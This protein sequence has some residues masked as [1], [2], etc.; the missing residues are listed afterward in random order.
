MNADLL[1]CPF[2]G[3]KPPKDLSDTLYPSGIYRRFEPEIGFT[4][5]IGRRDRL[6]T[7]EPC[8]AMHCTENMG[9]CGAQINGNTRDEAIAAWNTRAPQQPVQPAD[10][11]RPI[12]SAPKDGSVIIFGYTAN[13]RVN[14]HAYEGRWNEAQQTWTSVNGFILLAGANNWMPFPAPPNEVKQ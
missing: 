11:W 7:D 13:P 6:P 2:C 12:E 8:W 4:S 10:G 3:Y 1:P 14:H 5:F 9:G